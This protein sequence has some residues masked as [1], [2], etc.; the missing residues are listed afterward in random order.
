MYLRNGCLGEYLDLSGRKEQET[1]KFHNKEL[2]I[3]CYSP[4]IVRV[5]K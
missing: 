4:D 1:G 2:Y 3:L 5:I